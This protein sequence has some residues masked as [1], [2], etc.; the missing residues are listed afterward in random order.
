MMTRPIYRTYRKMAARVGASYIFCPAGWHRNS[1]ELAASSI[2][3][4]NIDT[5][6]GTKELEG[7]TAYC[8]AHAIAYVAGGIG[9]F[10]LEIR[11]IM[12]VYQFPG[13]LL[14]F[15]TSRAG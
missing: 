11:L 3:P 2:R 13:T 15:L 12:E 9:M 8:A 14:P 6:L 7:S 4:F 10:V 1:C 5:T